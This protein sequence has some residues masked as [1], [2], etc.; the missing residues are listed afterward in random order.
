MKRSDI[1]K[2]IVKVITY[3]TELEEREAILTAREIVNRIEAAGML[4]P[5]QDGFCQDHWISGAPGYFEYFQWDNE[6]DN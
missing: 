1:I 6:N 3:R 2:T 5:M 4:P